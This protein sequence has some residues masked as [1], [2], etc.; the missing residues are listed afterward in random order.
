MVKDSSV[1]NAP[2][3]VLSRKQ[4]TKDKVCFCWTMQ[5]RD[6]INVH[7]PV[8]EAELFLN[9][10]HLLVFGPGLTKPLLQLSIV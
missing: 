3:K 1:T 2:S 9:L 4:E 8:D 7:I 5:I 6:F 10:N